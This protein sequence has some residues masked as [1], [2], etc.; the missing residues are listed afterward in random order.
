MIREEE[1]QEGWT[2]ELWLWRKN[3]W[4]PYYL[5]FDNDTTLGELQ[6]VVRNY[7]GYESGMTRDESFAQ[8]QADYMERNWFGYDIE[9]LRRYPCIV[10]CPTPP[11][12]LFTPT[13]RVVRKDSYIE[14][15]GYLFDVPGPSHPVTAMFKEKWEAFER[16]RI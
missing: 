3:Q 2:L 12:G 7:V 8:F 16:A 11:Q 6:R 14:K 15:E 4:N 10:A 1:A 9:R 5:P 13:E